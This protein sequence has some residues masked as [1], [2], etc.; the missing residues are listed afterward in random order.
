M[1]NIIVNNAMLLV[2]AAVAASVM[3]LPT[4]EAALYTVGDDLGWTIPPGGAATYAA[5]AAKHSFVVKDILVFNFSAGEDDLAV[6]TKEDFD[7]CNTTDPLYEFQEPVTL[8]FL[9]S[10]TFY[11]TST[12]AGH[13]SKGQKLAV[14]FAPSSTDSPSP[15]PTSSFPLKFVS[16]KIMQGTRT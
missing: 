8:Q 13:C 14:Y 5:W 7:A 9:A 2:I 4:A 12:L 16:Q 11:F 6:V 1:N 3:M 10:D 15:S